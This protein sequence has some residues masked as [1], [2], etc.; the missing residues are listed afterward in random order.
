MA[1]EFILTSESV[2]EGHPD[3]VADRI[4][5]TVLDAHLARDPDARV[6]C[7]T[8]VTQNY[9][10]V[11]GE[12]R[13]STP[14]DAAEIEAAARAAIRDIGYVDFDGRFSADHVEVHVRLHA[15]SPEIAS[16][17][18]KLDRRSQG[19]GDQ[20]M[21]FG[22]ATGET[23]ELMPAPITWAH[24]L[25]AGLAAARKSG[26]VAWL[27]PDA[28]SQVSVR[29]ENGLPTEITRIVVSTQH[30]PEVGRE[31]I[32]AFVLEE[33]I[34]AALPPDR[35]PAGWADRVLVNPSGSFVEGGPATDTGLTGRKIIVDTYGGAAR[36][37]GGAFSGK[38][39]SKVDRSAAYAARWAAK[40]VVAA[41]LA[42][43]CE[44]CVAYA[45]GVAEPVAI[46][47]ETFGT[48]QAAE[49]L[50]RDFIRTRFDLTPRGI[51][52]DLDLL[53]PIYAPTASYG[54]FGRTPG[55]SRGFP[56]EAVVVEP[57]VPVYA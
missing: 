31:T 12:V 4:S 35:L 29:Y 3:K 36:H 19:A 17:V 24:A 45:I 57:V 43:R 22:Y 56:W 33:L 49:H 27:R 9:V 53:R 41:G 39:P 47:V 2:S 44:I 51:I 54:H 15:Q 5:D 26:G 25:T 1:G 50:I 7:E 52:E 34:P 46:G 55:A 40:N 13:S 28:K 37:G 14:L 10:C 38:D 48:A 42:R 32:R 23:P 16:A 8:L 11:A 20:G 30:T 21:M 6:A 18:D